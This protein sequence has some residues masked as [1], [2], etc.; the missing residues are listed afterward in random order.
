MSNEV[1]T[2]QIMTAEAQSQT[3]KKDVI[4]VGESGSND[5]FG[6]LVIVAVYVSPEA[7]EW[8][9][10][11]DLDM[12]QLHDNKKRYEI[13][14]EIESRCSFHPV[15]ITPSRYN[16]LFNDMPNVRDI[17]AWGYATAI[18]SLLQQ[19]DCEHVICSGFEKEDMILRKYLVS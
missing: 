17:T 18:D 2:R 16:E 9:K 14:N 12:S 11:C 4:I 8:F 7:I 13:I 1:S 19:V 15:I 10:T 6:P 5:Y 3:L